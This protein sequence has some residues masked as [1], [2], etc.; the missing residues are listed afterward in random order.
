MGMVVIF[1]YVMAVGL[2]I[3]MIKLLIENPKRNKK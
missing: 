3:E 2:V 1:L